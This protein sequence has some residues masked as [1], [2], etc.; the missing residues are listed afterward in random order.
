MLGRMGWAVA[1]AALAAGERPLV[2]AHRGGMAHRP[3]NT[4]VAFE[5][6]VRL[7]AG[8]LEFDMVVT[9]TAS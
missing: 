4:M 7:G 6:A 3:G 9:A 2:M 8:V 1:L 5:H